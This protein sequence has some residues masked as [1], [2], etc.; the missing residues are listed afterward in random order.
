MMRNRLVIED[1]SRSRKSTVSIYVMR[2]AFGRKEKCCVSNIYFDPFG[3]RNIIQ[4]H[5]SECGA[6]QI[7][8]DTAFEIN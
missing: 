5:K 6:L 4:L 1:I 8:L 3:K 7:K 2:G